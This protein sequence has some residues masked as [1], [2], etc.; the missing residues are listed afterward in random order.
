M[1]LLKLLPLSILLGFTY[2][3]ADIVK[4]YDD[5]IKKGKEIKK[6]AKKTYDSIFVKGTKLSATMDDDS[7]IHPD[8]YLPINWSKT[9]SSAIEYRT[10]QEIEKG[11]VSASYDSSDNTTTLD[12]EIINL[13]IIKYNL[14]NKYSKYSFGIGYSMESFDKNQKGSATTGVTTT[15]FNHNI[16]IDIKGISIFADSTYDKLTDKLSAKFNISLLTGST[17]DVKQDTVLT[18]SS[19]K[20]SSS[21]DLDLIYELRGKFNYVLNSFVDLGFETR[22]KFTPLKYSLQLQKTDNTFETK[23]YDVEEKITYTALNIYFK[24]KLLGDL[25][26][27]IGYISEKTKKL[28]KLDSTTSSNTETMTIFGLNSKF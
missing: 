25:R 15:T 16:D 19:S 21:E 2:G 11:I 5:V 18:S 8:I 26:P 9:F 20:G 17:L 27:M 7:N 28:N 22:Y 6:E 13:E 12:K 4:T 23:N 1:K 10:T 24:T 3:Q 14:K